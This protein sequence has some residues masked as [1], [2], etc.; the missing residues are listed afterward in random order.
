M[1]VVV[2]GDWPI[3]RNTDL[4]ANPPIVGRVTSLAKRFK[5]QGAEYAHA[6]IIAMAQEVEVAI[7]R[8]SFPPSNLEIPDIFV[9]NLMYTNLPEAMGEHFLGQMVYS[10]S[11]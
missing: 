5:T 4:V 9:T 11:A 7:R 1:M 3:K 2:R 8:G 10:F 6:F